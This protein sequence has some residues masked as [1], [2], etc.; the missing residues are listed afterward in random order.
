MANFFKETLPEYFELGRQQLKLA[1][2]IPNAS[3]RNQILNHF[4]YIHK[5]VE[6]PHNESHIL[7]FVNEMLAQKT[8][9]PGCFVEAG[10]FKG[11]SSSKLSIIA[12]RLNRKLFIFDSF[13]GLPPNS[14][15]HIK[16]TTGYS[17]EGWFE[18]KKFFGA[19]AEVKENIEK[20]G[21]IHSCEFLKGWFEETMPNFNEKILAAYIDVDLA[22]STKTCLKY[23]YPL[24]VPGGVICSQDGDF[25]LVIEALEDDT[26][27]ENELGINRPKIE[28]FKKS[29]IIKIRK[30]L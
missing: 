11:G 2:L 24:L 28:G 15:K 17:I 13:E 3:E 8:G 26:F 25:P 19:L 7:S 23:L 22:S 29:K 10:A 5:N 14:E 1:E 21:D 30:P 18:E 9:M 6:C 20:Y 4:R 27:W 12:K 16:S